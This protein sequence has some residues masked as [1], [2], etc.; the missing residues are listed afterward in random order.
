MKLLKVI[1]VF[2]FL[3]LITHEV[4]GQNLLQDK[5]Q[6]NFSSPRLSF[7]L[8]DH[9]IILP[10]TSIEWG[11]PDRWSLTS[12]YIHSFGERK[13]RHGII[14]NLFGGIQTQKVRADTSKEKTFCLS[15]GVGLPIYKHGSKLLGDLNHLPITFRLLKFPIAFM[16]ILD[17][18]R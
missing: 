14:I 10:I 18:S 12:R 1:F 8:S 4:S 13:K 11:I 6:K 17:Y 16:I 7:L 9:D 3:F 5:T 2:Y 15:F